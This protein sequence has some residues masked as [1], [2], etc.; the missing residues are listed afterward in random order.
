MLK[1]MGRE[2]TARKN[3]GRKNDGQAIFCTVCNVFVK[4]I[5]R[6][7]RSKRHLDLSNS[8]QNINQL[9]SNLL[10]QRVRC[11]PA[12]LT[13]NVQSQVD[14]IS[15]EL[16][17]NI[18]DNLSG[19]SD[20]NDNLNH[21]PIIEHLEGLEDDFGKSEDEHIH[22]NSEASVGSKESEGSGESESSKDNESS[23]E[24]ESDNDTDDSDDTPLIDEDHHSDDE[25]HVIKRYLLKEHFSMDNIDKRRRKL[26]TY[27]VQMKLLKILND[28]GVCP[29]VFNLVM[30]WVKEYFVIKDHV[31]P[32]QKFRKRETIMKAIK[33]MYGDI[34]GGSIETKQLEA[35]NVSCL[36]HR[37]D[38]LK[39][40]YRLLNNQYLMA[41]AQWLP[42]ESHQYKENSN[43]VEKVY[44]EVTSAHWYRRTYDCMLVKHRENQSPYPPLLVAIVL[45]QDGTLC[46]KVGRVSSEPILV[47]IANILYEKRKKHNAWFCIGFIPPYPKTQLEKQKD[48]NRIS[49]KELSNEFYHSSIEFI[50]EDLIKVQRNNGIEMM[51]NLNG[52]SE[53]R[54]CYFEVA[55]SLGDASGNHKLCGHYV[56]FSGNV[57]RKQRECN[58]SHLDSD[59][60]NFQC[61]FNIGE[62]NIKDTVIKC[63]NAINSKENITAHRDILKSISQ[64]AIIPAHFHFTYGE[65]SGG[66][67]T[68]T[69]PGVLHVLCENGLF[70]YLLR[71]LYHSV[72]IPT[73]FKDYWKHVNRGTYSYDY[74][75]KNY[76]SCLTNSESRKH[77][78]DT[79]EYERRIRVLV[80]SAKRQSDRSMVKCSSF[81]DGVTQLSRL[82]GQEYPGLVLLTILALDGLM[83]TQEEERK[84]QRLLNDSLILYQS[85]MVDKLTH[86]E[87]NSL[88]RT[89]KEYLVSYKK[90]IGPLQIMKSIVG[91]KLTKFHSPLHLCFFIRE[92]GAPLNFFEGHLEEF[93]KHFVKR[94]YPRTTR[95]HSR[96]LYDLTNRLQEKICLDLWVDDQNMKNNHLSS[97]NQSSGPTINEP[98]NNAKEYLNEENN[99]FLCGSKFRIVR[100]S[101][102][103]QWHTHVNHHQEKCTNTCQ[104]IGLYHPWSNSKFYNDLLKQ[105]TDEIDNDTEKDDS[106]KTISIVI[107][108][109]CKIPSNRYDNTAYDIIR[110]H[111]NY[112]PR[113]HLD[114]NSEM[115]HSA[116]H[117]WVEVEYETGIACGRVLL[118]CWIQF[119]GN[120][121]DQSY[122]MVQTLTGQGKKIKD[123]SIF[124]SYDSIMSNPHRIQFVPCTAIRSVAYVLPCID[125]NNVNRTE[126]KKYFLADH[127]QN[128]HFMIIKPVEL[129]K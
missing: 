128:R 28:E 57:C 121:N 55:F 33:K 17:S 110:A 59:N 90:L 69:P 52:E 22:R 125:H 74:L 12:N 117:D 44:S 26:G 106:L 29:K 24:C 45:G 126:Y 4:N 89:I 3:L 112:K 34:A 23:E 1:N 19:I 18:K 67:H 105:L 14:N 127:N 88:E 36:V 122:A 93:L 40:M 92:Y 83:S 10:E 54:T 11:T 35:C 9:S 95:Q 41:D 38:F 119:L 58:V 80:S 101:E 81:R 124:E 8:S 27:K 76:P 47:S 2:R 42:L 64:N 61:E 75:I 7:E 99:S 53:K 79:T 100:S 71:N 15:E 37:C 98:T 115:K 87:I 30:E 77:I 31:S 78:F 48:S 68:A 70:K 103:N 5:S 113:Q 66:I 97:N 50:L 49:T 109:E 20:Q 56:N 104:N 123:L 43:T 63:V 111:P 94:L 13:V 32:P 21:E 120:T 86:S 129:W 65:N 73:R 60:I 82:S 96:Y 107:C 16:N 84:Y 62:N 116:W 39:N 46:D 108:S 85:L 51:V 72:E 6:H 118:W 91:L 25:D 114:N 102:Y